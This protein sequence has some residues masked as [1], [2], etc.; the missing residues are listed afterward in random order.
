MHP[1][2][3]EERWLIGVRRLQIIHTAATRSLRYI[4]V[5]RCLFRSFQAVVMK[6]WVFAVLVPGQQ[7]GDDLSQA[8]DDPAVVGRLHVAVADR[9]AADDHHSPRHV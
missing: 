5:Q 1:E 9:I 7:G 3:R 6:V 4:P 8:G 2:K